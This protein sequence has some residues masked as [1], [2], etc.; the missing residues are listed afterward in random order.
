VRRGGFEYGMFCVHHSH[1]KSPD[2]PR[3][4]VNQKQAN[5]SAI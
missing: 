4:H 5:A 2:R 3:K 1:Y